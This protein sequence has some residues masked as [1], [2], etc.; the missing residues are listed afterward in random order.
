MRDGVGLDSSD[1]QLRA[2]APKHP[3]FR[4]LGPSAS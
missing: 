4:L 3:V 2:A 1:E